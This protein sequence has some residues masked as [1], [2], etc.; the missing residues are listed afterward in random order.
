MR[1]N[2]NVG[3]EIIALL[4]ALGAPAICALMFFEN[5][6]Q[7]DH[8]QGYACIG[9]MSAFAALMFLG[10]AGRLESVTFG[11][12]RVEILRKVDEAKLIESNVKEI[13]AA[14]ARLSIRTIKLPPDLMRTV[15]TEGM[16]EWHD[17]LIE[18][19][20][21]ASTLF[22]LAGTSEEEIQKEMAP[23]DKQITDTSGAK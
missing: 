15:D 5:K 23:L 7:K 21:I 19:K 1:A 18:I 4:L 17:H 22:H 9:A 12:T 6:F 11:S 20:K 2:V 13:A 16:K 10:S 8:W 3:L 14:T